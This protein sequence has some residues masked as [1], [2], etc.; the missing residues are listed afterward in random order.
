MAQ[1]I[2]A[3]GFGPELMT[4]AIDEPDPFAGDPS[5][6]PHDTAK[7]RHHSSQSS[8]ERVIGSSLATLTRPILKP[9]APTTGALPWPTTGA[10][11]GPSNSRAF[12]P[13]REPPYKGHPPRSTWARTGAQAGLVDQ[14]GRCC[15][16][17]WMSTSQRGLIRCRRSSTRSS[18]VGARF[19]SAHA[20][21]RCRDRQERA[22]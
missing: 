9:N 19:R 5:S 7:C 12:A 11:T 3:C 1:A 14:H 20:W 17:I 21:P 15:P 4:M 13:A 18:K 10:Q 16:R 22:A 6:E 8:T 2:L